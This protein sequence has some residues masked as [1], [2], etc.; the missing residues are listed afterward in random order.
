M[1][2]TL[3]CI[4]ILLLASQSFAGNKPIK[5]NEAAK[6]KY[7][8]EFLLQK[9][10]E[11]KNQAFNPQIPLPSLH[12]ESTTPLKVFQ[13]AIESQWGFRPDHFTNAFS[14]K[15][16][17]IF[18]SDDASYYE[19]NGRC[20]DDSLVHELVHYVQDKYLHWDLND[21]SLEWDAIGIQTEFRNEYCP[22]KNS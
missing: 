5:P 14:V 22:I 15:F 13:D 8:F 19:R 21:E 16:N 7:P 11:K 17:T 1:K 2:K 4:F 3:T 9:V 10:L 20:M 6:F 12:M 18:V